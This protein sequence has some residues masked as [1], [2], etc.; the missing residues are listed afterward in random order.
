MNTEFELKNNQLSLGP[1]HDQLLKEVKLIG[2]ELV[3]TFDIKLYKDDYLDEIYEK[4]KDFKFCDL[5]IRITDLEL[6]NANLYS[7][8]DKKNRFAGIELDI[9]E[10]CQISKIANYIQ[11]GYCYTN[12]NA[13]K[14]DLFCDFY[15]AKG[16]NRKYKKYSSIDMTLIAE[17]VSCKWY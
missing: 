3:F 14:V 10:F 4:Y 9:N 15:D 13:V 12:S 11:F 1:L 2:N 5:T 7:C 16:K 6:S 17:K 8:L